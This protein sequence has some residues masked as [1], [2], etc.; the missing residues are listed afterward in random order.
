MLVAVP[1]L[2]V[3]FTVEHL[4]P[5]PAPRLDPSFDQATAVG[6]ASDLAR[7]FPDRSPGSAGARGATDW[8]ARQL[9]EY[10][11]KT[12]RFPFSAEV[13]GAG[14]RKLVNVAAVMRA[15]HASGAEGASQALVVMAHRDNAG[16]SP[17]ANDNASGTGVLLELARNAHAVT[18]AH[19]LVFLSTE[20]G[21]LGGL[22]A[23]EFAR[24]PEYLER[25]A[26]RGTSA[27]AVVNLDSL[28]GSGRPR[29]VFAGD[30]ARSP[31]EALLA[32]ADASV[33]AETGSAPLPPHAVFQLVD[34]AFPFSLYEQAPLVGR[35]VAA[36]TL[37][38]AQERPE[39]DERDTPEAIDPKAIGAIGRAAQ[40]L[41]ASLDEAG[42]AAGATGSYLYLGSRFVSGPA[43][44]LLLL[45][46]LLPFLAAVLDLFARCRRHGVSLTHGL[47]VL[48]TRIALWAWAAALAA[49]FV[50]SG[51]LP[52]RAVR[53]LDPGSEVARDWPVAALL[54]L[55]A[56]S[57][58]GW[59]VV[60]RRLAPRR[61]NDRREELGGHLAAMLALAAV[62]LVVAA[63][64]P[65]ALVFVLPSLHAWL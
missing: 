60:R 45:F 23:A 29:L 58:L 61:S 19:T 54:A 64:N 8:I 15:R 30:T 25:M 24:H 28:G 62:A 9:A 11:L 40:A 17:G 33:R 46:A 3:A 18:L 10:G 51:L 4:D 55:L 31:S 49:V 56:L 65:Y 7:R 14:T 63:T 52:G 27:L 42:D 57:I 5:P 38:T 2:V 37:T 6:F 41:L 12:V 21:A 39:P 48:R 36:V 13:P 16:S 20:G 44:Q 53:P 34:L 26:G 50:A 1:L 32:L 22:G 47:R 59:V 43:I 35:E